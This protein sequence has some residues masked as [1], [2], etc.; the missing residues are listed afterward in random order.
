[1]KSDSKVSKIGIYLLR[2]GLITQDQVNEVLSEQSKI[3]DF[4]RSRFGRIAVNKGY[5]TE[6]ALNLAMMEKYESEKNYQKKMNKGSKKD[7][8]SSYSFLKD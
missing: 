6:H 4:T 7:G 5:I 1:M 3:N 8:N 2:K